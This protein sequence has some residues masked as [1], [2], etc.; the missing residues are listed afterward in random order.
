MPIQNL[1]KEKEHKKN[2]QRQ[3]DSKTRNKAR[4]GTEK[5]QYCYF[6]NNTGFCHFET[7]NGRQGKFEYKAAPRCNYDGNCNRKL[8]MYTHQNQ[9]V[10]FLAQA[11]NNSRTGRGT[12]GDPHPHV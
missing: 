12:I 10:A 5:I 11:Q 8:C 4:G 6:W 1:R 9:N 2:K 3:E 7:K